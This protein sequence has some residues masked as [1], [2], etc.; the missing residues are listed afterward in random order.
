MSKTIRV[1]QSHGSYFDVDEH[2]EGSFYRGRTRIVITGNAMGPT[3]GL[4]VIRFTKYHSD[5]VEGSWEFAG[6]PYAGVYLL[7]DEWQQVFAAIQ[8]AQ[9][10]DSRDD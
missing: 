4:Q 5:E 9:S 1:F 2:I 3:K 8:L 6:N 7:L 10:N